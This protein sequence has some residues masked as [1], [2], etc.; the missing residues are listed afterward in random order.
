MSEAGIDKLDELIRQFDTAMLVTQSLD[1]ALR[2]R[3]MAIAEHGEGAV[4]YFATRS[5]DEKLGEILQS[6][7]VA[8]TMQADNIYLSISGEARV[9]TNRLLAD[10]LWTAS[11]RLWFPEGPGDPDLVILLFE[12]TYAEYWDRAG[13][14]R[15]QFWW[16]AGKA[17]SRGEKTN[18]DDLS[19]HDKVTL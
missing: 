19:G 18:A 3:P 1:G 4:L 14:Q 6:P 16:E 7:G 15:L 2:A 8:V 10:E 5:E 12:P 11:M 13:M 9:L 17:L